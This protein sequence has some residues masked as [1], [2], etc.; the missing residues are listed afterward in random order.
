MIDTC[1]KRKIEEPTI[2]MQTTTW[3]SVLKR[4]GIGCFEKEKLG[5]VKRG[6]WEIEVEGADYEREILKGFFREGR[7]AD[8]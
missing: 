6:H 3:G 2:D 1:I 8:T 5:E 7:T 4:E